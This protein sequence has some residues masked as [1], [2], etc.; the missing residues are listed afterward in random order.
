VSALDDSSASPRH[1]A[2]ASSP[3]FR[4]AGG[5][6][7]SSGQWVRTGLV[8]RAGA[9][10]LALSDLVAVERLDLHAIYDLRT[11]EEIKTAPDTVPAGA[12]WLSFNVSGVRG[13]TVPTTTTPEQAQ[14][15][16]RQGVVATATGPSALSAYHDLFT[17]MADRP[18]ASVYHCT[19]GKD[20]TGWA[21]V[22]LLTLL[23]VPEQTVL[24]DY[25]LSNEY[26]FQSAYVQAMLAD[27][28][29]SEARVFRHYM[30]VE[31][32]YLQAGLE[33]VRQ[34]YGS[35]HDYALHGL[36]LSPTT[37]DRLRAKLIAD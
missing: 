18:G 5:Y 6:R 14:E 4:D 10:A 7:T 33:A 21:S 29:E 20:R 1:F 9:L 8:Y 34:R 31:S 25:L 17:D 27:R 2:L 15:F 35:M 24:D 23:G 16:M 19:A 30:Q 11:P 36:R 28:P 13:V 3:N 32:S 26:Y 37:L 12:Q 22:V